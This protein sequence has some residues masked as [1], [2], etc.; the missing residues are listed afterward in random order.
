MRKKPAVAA[1]DDESDE[2]IAASRVATPS[3]SS[4]SDNEDES[5]APSSSRVETRSLP[6]HRRFAH[7]YH[8]SHPPPQGLAAEYA[9]GKEKGTKGGTKGRRLMRVRGA[10][11]CRERDAD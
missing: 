1:A 5:P 11:E 2:L 9:R 10:R 6:P 3:R 7:P 8:P 4:S